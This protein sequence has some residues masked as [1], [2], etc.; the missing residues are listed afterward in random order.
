MPCTTGMQVVYSQRIARFLHNIPVRKHDVDLHWCLPCLW[1]TCSYPDS[2]SCHS[3]GSSGVGDATAVQPA[4][5]LTRA[6]A[7]IW[8]HPP[9]GTGVH[10][11][12][13]GGCHRAHTPGPRACASTGWVIFRTC[14]HSVQGKSCLSL[15]LCGPP[16]PICLNVTCCRAAHGVVPGPL[17]GFPDVRPGCACWAAGHAGRRYADIQDTRCPVTTLLHPSPDTQSSHRHASVVQAAGCKVLRLDLSNALLGMALVMGGLASF[18][19]SLQLG[20]AFLFAAWAAAA[21]LGMPAAGRVSWHCCMACST[22]S[23]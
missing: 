15:P 12:R 21:L 19:T 16:C 22:G 20:S 14:R 23:C 6:A 11:G 8:G 5:P 3:P 2:S 9:R 13:A 10:S 7:N 18:L 1:Q 17:A 4:R